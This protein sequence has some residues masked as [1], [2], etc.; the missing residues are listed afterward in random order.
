[1]KV[2]IEYYAKIPQHKKYDGRRTFDNVRAINGDNGK[3]IIEK[4]DGS[5]ERELMGAI[6]EWRIKY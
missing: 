5:V 4:G 2:E 3:F 6:R 1:M